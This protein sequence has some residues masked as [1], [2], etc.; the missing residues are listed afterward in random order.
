MSLPPRRLARRSILAAPLLLVPAKA[1]AA[2]AAPPFPQWV[3]R[4]ALLRGDG[5]AAT[6]LFSGDGTGLLTVRFL[7]FCRALPIRNWQFGGDGLSVR[8]SRVSARDPALLIAG[9]AH[10]LADEGELLWIEATRR[11][12]I[13]QGFSAASSGTG[14]F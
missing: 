2:Q 13:F 6:L 12:A 3:G 1:S 5:G 8:Y 9:E 4:T 10:I 7:L 14:C 11:I